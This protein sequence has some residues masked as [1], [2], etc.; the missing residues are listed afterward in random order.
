MVD[1]DFSQFEALI[2]D[3][4]GTLVDNMPFHRQTWL[5]WA[6]QEGIELPEDEVLALTHGTIGEIVARFFPDKSSEERY[7]IGE[8]KEALYRELYAPHLRLLPGLEDLLEWT[9]AQQM[10]IALA[11]A[12]DYN[13][14][15]FTLDGLEIR[16]YFQALVGSEDVTR[17]KPHPEV[18]LL[19]AQKLGVAPEKCL[20]FEDSPAGVEAAR[21]AGMKCVALNL[22]NPRD[23]FS[24]TDHVIAWVNDYRELAHNPWTRVSSREIYRNPWIMVTEDQVIRPDGQSGI[25]GHVGMNSWAV[26]VVPLHEDGTVTLV[27]QYRYTMGQYSWEIPEGGCP[28]EERP[29]DC[30]RRELIEET[31]LRAARIKPLGGEI[32][33][34]NSVTNERGYLFVATELTEGE[35][36]PEGTEELALKRVPLERAVE[37]VLNG[38]I[39]DV[40]TVTALLLLERGRRS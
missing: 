25:Y 30:A 1:F 17:G 3:M 19:A 15:A 40:L 34:S 20:V 35:A 39:N 23:E 6:P 13:N 22:M 37:M 26:G 29:I 31:G 27:G 11:T 38:E 16:P 18:F 5:Q 14:I 2:F 8:R 10:P 32:Q 4:D 21:R 9:R 12:G 24:E 28:F 36:A 7:Q 33:L